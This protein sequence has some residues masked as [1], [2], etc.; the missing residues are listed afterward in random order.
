MKHDTDA[1]REAQSRLAQKLQ[2][3]KNAKRGAEKRLTRNVAAYKNAKRGAE[4]ILRQN[5]EAYKNALLGSSGPC[6][7][8]NGS[9]SITA[10][11]E[12]KLGVID[13]LYTDSHGD[14]WA[15]KVD[16]ANSSPDQLVFEE[17]HGQRVH[18]SYPRDS[19]ASDSI[20]ITGGVVCVSEIM[21]TDAHGVLG[22]QG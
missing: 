17:Q 4:K 12:L 21:Y 14:Q 18:F 7:T 20:S 9:V 16:N 19:T 15:F 3:Y 2:T 13:V 1:R 11:S 6:S 22:I 8:A 5:V 10:H